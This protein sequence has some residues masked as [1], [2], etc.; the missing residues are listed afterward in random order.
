MLGMATCLPVG[1]VAKP[2]GLRMLPVLDGFLGRGVFISTTHLGGSGS[3]EADM[4]DIE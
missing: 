1:L 4:L 2:G 3:G